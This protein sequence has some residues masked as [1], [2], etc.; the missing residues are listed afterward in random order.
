[1]SHLPVFRTILNATKHQE[2]M[3]ILDYLIS[4]FKCCVE[5]EETKSTLL[6]I[7]TSARAICLQQNRDN[8]QYTIY[9]LSKVVTD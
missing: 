7:N 8:I 4:S 5:D 2:L 9:T 3:I 1:M 6:T